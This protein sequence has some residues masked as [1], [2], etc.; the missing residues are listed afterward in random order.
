MLVIL[1][2]DLTQKSSQGETFTGRAFVV[3][4]WYQTAY[5]PIK[6]DSGRFIGIFYVGIKQEAI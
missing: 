4:V 1:V 5:K 6:D 2:V 3:N